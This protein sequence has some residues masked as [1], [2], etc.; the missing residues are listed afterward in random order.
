MT[1]ELECTVYKSLAKDDTYIYLP[2]SEE[3]SSLPRQLLVAL[4]KTEKVMELVLTPEKKLARY[5]GE[6]VLQSINEQGFHLQMPEDPQLNN[7]LPTINER[8][9]DKNI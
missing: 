8:F 2:S 9:L 5:S 1:N 4:G 7:P 3:I 6:E